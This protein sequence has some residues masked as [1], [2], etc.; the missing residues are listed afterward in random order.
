[1]NRYILFAILIGFPSSACADI[2]NAMQAVCRVTVTYKQ[3]SKS[4]SKVKVTK[5]TIGSGVI[6]RED[7]KNFWILTAGHVV[8]KKDIEK[9]EVAFFTKGF[10]TTRF[11]VKRIWVNYTSQAP[12][13]LAV[14]ALEKASLSRWH[15]PKLVPV[16]PRTRQLKKFQTILTT[17]CP[18]GGWPTT[19]MGHI[20][21]V[22]DTTFD[23]VP[24]PHKGRS[25][26][27]VFDEDGK[28][29]I[30]IV[31]WWRD[32]NGSKF[33]TAVSI[34]GIYRYTGW[35]KSKRQE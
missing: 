30:G 10:R 13:D 31:I 2:K 33:G 22:S 4:D 24:C 6:Y 27:A 25:G 23:L 11:K 28:E 21:N 1:M 12:N 26:S 3:P 8:S 20:K 7:E 18:Q 15:M 34:E 32:R 35:G 16:A 17:G 5:Y 29:I 19:F 14:L 9:I